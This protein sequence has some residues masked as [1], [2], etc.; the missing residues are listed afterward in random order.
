M[1]PGIKIDKKI[2][3]QGIMLKEF[4]RALLK[5]RIMHILGEFRSVREAASS[6]D[7]SVSGCFQAFRKHE[8]FVT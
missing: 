1:G 4:F 6:L 7:L 3:R 5:Q 2:T 8:S